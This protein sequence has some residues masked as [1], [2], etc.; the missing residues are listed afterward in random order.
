MADD[1]KSQDSGDPQHRGRIQAQGS[2]TEKSVP[3]ARDSAPSESEMLSFCDE[4]EGRLT[5]R[6]KRDREQPLTELREYIRR[7]AKFGGI[8]ANPR[9]HKKSFLKRGAKDIRV[10][11]EVQKG[12]ACIPDPT[13]E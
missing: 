4:L 13:A 10:D 5:E 11:L 1:S 7:V 8:S 9:P 3:W 2:G 6:E 12:M